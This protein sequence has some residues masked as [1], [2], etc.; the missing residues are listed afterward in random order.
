MLS[1][2]RLSCLILLVAATLSS[3]AVKV[4]E[5]PLT[6]PT[7]QLNTPDLNP[8][9]YTNESYQG[10]QKRV[11][12]YAMQDGVTD[13]RVEQTYKALYLETSTSSSA[14]CRKSAAAC[15]TRRIRRT[16]TRFST[17]STWSSPP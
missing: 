13:V 2:L 5:A 16:T 4:W 1:K 3:G 10:A 7:Y 14:S 11:Y 8:R 9:F 17:D 6:I 15:S 12:P